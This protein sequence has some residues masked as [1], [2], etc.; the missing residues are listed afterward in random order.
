M[1]SL[2]LS[3]K[4]ALTA[5]SAG[6]GKT[7]EVS[8]HLYEAIAA[9][10]VRPECTIATTFSRTG[11]A[12]LS[13]RCRTRLLEA[14]LHEAAQRLGGARI[15]TVNAVCSEIVKES[16][17]ELGLPPVLDVLS[18]ER[19]ATELARCLDACTT[20]AV[21]IE[22]NAL[23]RRLRIQRNWRGNGR[24]WRGHVGDILAE[25]QA[26]ALT[27]GQ[28]RD[29]AKRS[30]DSYSAILSAPQP[31]LDVDLHVLN[32]VAHFRSIAPNC[33]YKGT[34]YAM[35]QVRD[36]RTRADIEALGWA[37][38]VRLSRLKI[39]KTSVAASAGTL[40]KSAFE[41]HD[42]HPRLVADVERWLD[43]VYGIAA[44]ALDTFAK[45]KAAIGVIDFKDQE[46][47]ALQILTTPH[48]ASRFEGRIDLLVV[49][50]FQDSSPIQLAIFM[51]LAALARK[52]LWVGDRKQCVYA[53]RGADPELM[54]ACLDQLCG[55]EPKTLPH[56]WRSRPE[57][58]HLTSEVYADAF[59]KVGIPRKQVVLNT[60]PNKTFP[61]DLGAPVEHW[62][63]DADEAPAI[64]AG[65]VDLVADAS[66]RVRDRKNDHSSRPVLAGDVAVICR[67]NRQCDEIA[68]ALHDQ[69]QRC[70]LARGGLLDTW[71]CI[72]AFAALRL[73]VDPRDGTAVSELL[74]VGAPDDAEVWPQRLIEEGPKTALADNLQAVRDACVRRPLAGPIE[75]FDTAI[76]ASGLRT[77]CHRWGDAKHRLANV[78]QLREH[79]LSWV[80]N[81]ESAGQ[82]VTPAGLVRHFSALNDAGTDTFPTR[83]D[84]G[85]V[86]AM[87]WH[88]AKGLEWPIVVLV[89]LDSTFSA[90]VNQATVVDDRDAIDPD[91]PLDGRWIR[92]WPWPYDPA[93]KT[94]LG[95]RIRQSKVFVEAQ[96]RT[97][98]E[99][100]R[101]RYVAW[102]RARD[103][104]V[105]T[106]AVL[107][108]GVAAHHNGPVPVRNTTPA[109]LPAADAAPTAM[110][111]WTGPKA[112]APAVIYPS[113]LE[114]IGR[115]T[116]QERI[117][118]P[119]AV[120]WSSLGGD[121]SQVGEAVHGFLAADRGSLTPSHRLQIARRQLARWGVE[122]VLAPDAVVAGGHNLRA[123]VSRRWPE[124][125]WRREWPIRHILPERTVLR[126]FVDLVLDTEEGLIVIDHKSFPLADR[127]VAA[128]K[129]SEH[130]GQ[131][132]A[133]AGAIGRALGRPILACW[134]HMPIA[135]LAF[136]VE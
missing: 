44:D 66:T 113:D 17:Y 53:F 116:G 123:W 70:V 16:A 62:P 38:W 49:D 57:L 130:A 14:G 31:G 94:A 118:T 110:V 108:E 8:Q 59:S 52:S 133:Y 87:T 84:A 61:A 54:E 12:E 96:A 22:L 63:C 119:T 112:H 71:E 92:L 30:A 98:R 78:D 7:F 60:P 50:E 5:A 25:A 32:V 9:G 117:G 111:P 29:A 124:A 56:S 79:A 76:E 35:D 97:D 82:P 121:Y 91:N 48:L 129:A 101:L 55:G 132:R 11:A 83:P 122:G 126:G 18:E 136:E 27:P 135:G 21:R 37:D 24:N 58:V 114:A 39:P 80:S 43:L 107:P 93:N 102:T 73:W 105:F 45:H 4:I 2:P 109:A 106:G 41:L 64:A 42:G 128:K 89:G 99:E 13:E 85:A 86:T 72:A 103:R 26:N 134:V 81:S 69:G 115:V 100:L 90:R 120:N 15:G 33:S 131:L 68:E 23:G 67:T 36:L 34:R 19:A 6:S 95:E 127:A 28:V 20:Q 47:L 104:V 125:E 1:S 46:Q 88:K 77:L 65:V 40:M 10:E 75:A 51:R 3:H 74:R